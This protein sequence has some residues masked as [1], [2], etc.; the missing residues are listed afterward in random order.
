[1]ARRKRSLTGHRERMAVRLRL[2]RIREKKRLEDLK[3][4]RKSIRDPRNG[5]TRLSMTLANKQRERQNCMSRKT[6]KAQPIEYV[7]QWCFMKARSNLLKTRELQ[8]R[9]GAPRVM[10]ERLDHHEMRN[11]HSTT[12]RCSD[13]LKKDQVNRSGQNAV[14]SNSDHFRNCE[15]TQS[16]TNIG[17]ATKSENAS[18]SQSSGLV[19]SGGQIQHAGHSGLVH[20][21]GLVQNVGLVQNFGLVPTIGPIP[22]YGSIHILGQTVITGQLYYMVQIQCG[23]TVDANGRPVTLDLLLTGQHIQ[24]LQQHQLTQGFLSEALSQQLLH[25]M[26]PAQQK[27]L[28]RLERLQQQKQYRQ[29]QQ[30]EQQQQRLQQQQQQQLKQH[31][32][33]KLQQGKYQP[34]QQQQE[35][36]QQKLQHQ[37]QLRQQ[38]QSQQQ[39]QQQWK[40]QKIQQQWQFQQQPQQNLAIASPADDL[41]QRQQDQRPG[42]PRPTVPQPVSEG[43]TLSKEMR[44]DTAMHDKQKDAVDAL[45]LMHKQE[46]TH[47]QQPQK[48]DTKKSQDNI[49]DKERDKMLPEH[50]LRTIDGVQTAEHQQAGIRKTQAD[51]IDK[52]RNEMLAEHTLRT[53]EGVQIVEHQGR[54]ELLRVITLEKWLQGENGKSREREEFEKVR[55]KRAKEAARQ[56]EIRKRQ[57]EARDAWEKSQEE[58]IERLRKIV[59]HLQ[60]TDK[61]V[62]KLCGI[63]G[64]D[65]MQINKEDV[66]QNKQNNQQQQENQSGQIQLGE[67]ERGRPGRPKRMDIEKQMQRPDFLKEIALRE[68]AKRAKEA[69]RVAENRRKRKAKVDAWDEAKRQEIERLRKIIEQHEN[70]QIEQREQQKQGPEDRGSQEILEQDS[71]QKQTTDILQIR[72]ESMLQMESPTQV[73]NF[74]QKKRKAAKEQI[75]TQQNIIRIEVGNGKQESSILSIKKEDQVAKKEKERLAKDAA[76]TTENR[77]KRKAKLYDGDESKRQEIERLQKKIEQGGQSVQREQQQQQERRAENN[78]AHEIGRRGPVRKE[79]GD[80]KQTELEL[81]QHIGQHLLKQGEKQVEEEYIRDLGGHDSQPGEQGG[82]NQTEGMNLQQTESKKPEQINKEDKQKISKQNQPDRDKR[83]ERC[84]KQPKLMRIEPGKYEQ[85]S[86][87]FFEKREVFERQKS[88]QAKMARVAEDNAKEIIVINAELR[89]T[90]RINLLQRVQEIPRETL[91]REW[92]Q[93][94]RVH[95]QGAVRE[96]SFQIVSKQ[97]QMIAQGDAQVTEHDVSKKMLDEE[98]QKIVQ[99]GSEQLGREDEQAAVSRNSQQMAPEEQPAEFREPEPDQSQS[100]AEE[101]AQQKEHAKVTGE[102]SQGMIQENSQM[103]EQGG[104]RKML[105]SA[106]EEMVVEE[107]QDRGQ[108]ESWKGEW[109]GLQKKKKSRR[110]GEEELQHKS[111]EDSHE[112]EQGKYKESC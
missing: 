92:Q 6:Q 17:L 65:P 74:C 70:E 104:L 57:K 75:G 1:M 62:G 19:C 24:T 28:R 71:Q 39:Q 52:E 3:Y 98:S 89:K 34:L 38:Q 61:R 67:E 64:Q 95:S 93:L 47:S 69:R 30:F 78:E 68:K 5:N 10:L 43:S 101:K 107:P 109:G 50:A 45:L 4:K 77:C 27:R 76:R 102:E 29:Q 48:G 42:L 58:E 49:V 7:P 83:R 9:G 40:Q 87:D 55:A 18:Q 13:E 84:E 8:R 51:V 60:K 11:S 21:I 91:P 33:E 94:K 97:S 108:H 90:G 99:G 72:A 82:L 110:T 37:Q 86:Y 23:D 54:P 16:H 25:A 105:L 14:Q 66:N 35:Q 20:N 41:T 31:E 53:L 85:G 2:Q 59:Q 32:E 103:I 80:L 111:Q 56:A 79:E 81:L 73:N 112:M 44:I 46:E 63:Q 26:Q 36:Q 100:I 15:L 106:F 96:E 88:R 22:N 12:E